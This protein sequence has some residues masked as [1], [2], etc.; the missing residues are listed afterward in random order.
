MSQWKT[1]AGYK[2]IRIRPGARGTQL[3]AI[4]CET[5]TFRFN[6]HPKCDM[7]LEEKRVTLS[8]VRYWDLKQ[9]RARLVQVASKGTTVEL[10][11]LGEDRC[12]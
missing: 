8:G 2:R 1:V 5:S 12:R 4:A 7:F 10:E 6:M 11:S 9:G 3:I